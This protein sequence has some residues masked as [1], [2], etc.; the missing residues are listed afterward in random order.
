MKF[1][2]ISGRGGEEFADELSSALDAAYDNNYVLPDL[3]KY[4]K[5]I[6]WMIMINGCN[7]NVAFIKFW[8]SDLRF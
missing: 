2:I 8:V 3:K 4:L 6:M 1:L 7:S 5:K